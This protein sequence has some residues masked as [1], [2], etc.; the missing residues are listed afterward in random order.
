MLKQEGKYNSGIKRGECGP[1]DQL[2]ITARVRTVKRTIVRTQL[3]ETFF[4]AL[5]ERSCKIGSCGGGGIDA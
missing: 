3:A 2:Y 4:L 5:I 1:F